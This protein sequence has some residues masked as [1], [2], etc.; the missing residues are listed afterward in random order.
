MGQIFVCEYEPDMLSSPSTYTLLQQDLMLVQP[1]CPKTSLA[2]FM[3]NM[4]S[5]QFDKVTTFK[6]DDAPDWPVRD[7]TGA[8][9]PRSCTPRSSSSTMVGRGLLGAHA[10]QLRCHGT[11]REAWDDTGPASLGGQKR[12]PCDTSMASGARLLSRYNRCICGFEKQLQHRES[13]LMSI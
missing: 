8:S 9:L 13:N 1:G 5:H 10:P 2:F 12:A 3:T 7:S 11:S 6:D 4:N